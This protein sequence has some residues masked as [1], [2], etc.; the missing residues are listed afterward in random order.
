MIDQRTLDIA[1]R[2]L[3]AEFRRREQSLARETRNI[4][5]RMSSRGVLMSS[6]TVTQITDLTCLELRT[7]AHV[8][9]DTF[10]R[11]LSDT[12]VSLSPQLAVELTSWLDSFINSSFQS[13]ARHLEQAVNN[14]G[15]GWEITPL[16]DEAA[17]V[18]REFAAR[19]D[20][21]VAVLEKRAPSGTGSAPTVMHFYGTVGAVQTGAVSSATVS[22]HI[23]TA[24]LTALATAVER[25]ADEVG[26]AADLQADAQAELQ[27]VLADIRQELARQKPNS[28][29]LRQLAMGAAT[30]IQTTA[31]LRPAYEALRTALAP[32]GILLP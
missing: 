17:A 30:A 25:L 10:Q 12:G 26:A 7:R 29:R 8:A 6:M 16:Q 18:K 9:W 32:L 21:L 27:E 11:V 14:L 15:I 22:Q 4:Q 5:E 2:L 19:A 23:G 24:D 28:I 20:L 13:L 31:S 1:Q 3:D